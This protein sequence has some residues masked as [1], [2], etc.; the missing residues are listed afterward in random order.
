M[1]QSGFTMAE[2]LVVMS[3]L[4]V[5]G[6]LGFPLVRTALDQSA[7]R[8]GRTAL[9]TLT[10]AARTVATQRGCRAVVHVSPGP[11]GHVW[12]TTCA[13]RGAGHDT[14]V[15]FD[16]VAAR[17]GVV[18]TPSRDSIQYDPRGLTLQRAAATIGVSRRAARDSLVINELGK[19]VR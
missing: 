19:V 10:V 15:A 2:S 12:V 9:A 1:R 11:N 3:V 6:A 4:G 14:L 7:V 13:L 8:S 17:F 18:L 5:L 16:P